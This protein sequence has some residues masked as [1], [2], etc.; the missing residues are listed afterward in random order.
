MKEKDAN[1]TGADTE[2]HVMDILL[3]SR[4]ITL[5]DDLYCDTFMLV[6]QVS[7]IFFFFACILLF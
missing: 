2:K 6:V 1:R 4:N 3:I 7:F 5:F